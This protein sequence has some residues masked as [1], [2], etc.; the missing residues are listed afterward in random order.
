[1]DANI[2]KLAKTM[3]RDFVEVTSSYI[4]GTDVNRGIMSIIYTGGDEYYIGTLAELEGKKVPD[5]WMPL[6][7]LKMDMDRLK[8]RTFHI[9]ET[10]PI[11]YETEDLKENESFMTMQAKKAAEGAT[12]FQAAD[13]YLMYCTSSIHPLN[14]TDS[15]KMRIYPYDK[16]SYL[17]C[18]E[19]TKKTHK[20]YE[21]IRYLY[22]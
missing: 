12:L 3:K 19:I 8:T 9:V 13:Q 11:I 6:D 22:L 1:M 10:Q 17:S 4:L 20:I 21:Y 2:I 14:K 16:I 5:F 7:R 15:I 18:Y